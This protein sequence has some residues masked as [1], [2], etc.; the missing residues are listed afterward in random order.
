MKTATDQR[1]IKTRFAADSAAPVNISRYRRQGPRLAAARWC[2]M[3]TCEQVLAPKFRIV[4]G[5]GSRCLNK[6][7]TCGRPEI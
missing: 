6:R 7:Q 5:L 2:Q 1:S 4:S 3:Q